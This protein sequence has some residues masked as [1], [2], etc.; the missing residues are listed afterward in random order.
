MRKTA[1]RSLTG[2]LVVTKGL[3]LAAALVN[4][5]SALAGDFV[6]TAGASGALDNVVVPPGETCNM[7][8]A[9]VEGS[10]KVYGAL[11]VSPPTTIRGS[12]DGEPGHQYVLLH[13]GA[14]LVGGD[15]QLKGSTAGTTGGYLDGTQIRGDF[16][17]EENAGV[18]TATGGTIRGNVK[19][20]KNTGGGS[21]TGNTIGGNLECKENFPLIVPSGNAIGGDL[22]CPE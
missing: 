17:W 21:I 16:Q 14:I 15:V 13:G 1:M 9:S 20:E 8:G 7:V 22:K 10:V 6:C 4:A 11:D 3:V 12:I 18:L 2:K 5:S 19:A